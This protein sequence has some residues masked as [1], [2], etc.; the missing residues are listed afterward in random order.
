M[1]GVQYV[2]REDFG[3]PKAGG[4][5]LGWKYGAEDQVSGL[6]L[7]VLQE[8]CPH[9]KEDEVQVDDRDHPEEV[10]C[11]CMFVTQEAAEKR[12]RHFVCPFYPLC[13]AKGE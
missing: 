11:F 8:D 6:N 3:E 2:G 12:P 9:W 7:F 5:N 10:R 13:Y 1:S 4:V